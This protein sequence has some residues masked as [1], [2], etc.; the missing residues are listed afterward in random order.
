MPKGETIEVNADFRRMW[1]DGVPTREMAKRLGVSYPSV[2]RAALRAG[3]PSR[4]TRD[5]PRSGHATDAEI[6]DWIE[7]RKNGERPD[8]INPERYHAV[9]G[10]TDRVLKADIEESGEP[11]SLVRAAYW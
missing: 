6:L 1:G 2:N 11:E 3:L 4:A 5:K 7:R 10:A 8:T 9:R